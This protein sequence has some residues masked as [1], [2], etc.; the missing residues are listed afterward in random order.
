MK[1]CD[2]TFGFRVNL[3][4]QINDQLKEKRPELQTPEES[5]QSLKTELLGK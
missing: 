3:V 4:N 2:V 1:D 5:V